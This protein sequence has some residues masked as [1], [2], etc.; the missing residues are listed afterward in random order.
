VRTVAHPQKVLPRLALEPGAAPQNVTRWKNRDGV[1]IVTPKKRRPINL[2][3]W[4]DAKSA[5]ARRAG[6]EN[7]HEG[8]YIFG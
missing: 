5:F 6:R 8:G 3:N 7:R 1:N 4:S 2:W